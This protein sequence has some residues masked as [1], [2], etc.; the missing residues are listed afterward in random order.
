MFFVT[1]NRKIAIDWAIYSVIEIKMY[2]CHMQYLCISR[3]DLN[4]LWCIGK[5]TYV[6]KRLSFLSWY[7]LFNLF[8]K[9]KLIIETLRAYQLANS[10]CF[11]KSSNTYLNCYRGYLISN[12][13]TQLS[14]LI[15]SLTNWLNYILSDEVRSEMN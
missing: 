4:S 5:G 11:Q 15:L 7:D 6:F 13:F 10:P 12:L 2:I 8:F 9:V 1:T 14:R 3:I